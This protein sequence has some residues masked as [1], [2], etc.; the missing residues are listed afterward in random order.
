[1]AETVYY[2]WRDRILEAGRGAMAGKE[3]D[4]ERT[5]ERELQRKVAELERALDRKPSSRRSAKSNG[6][7]AV[8]VRV[9]RSR[10]LGAAGFALAAGVAL[11]HARRA[12]SGMSRHVLV[13]QRMK[14]N[15]DERGF[16]EWSPRWPSTSTRWPFPR[17]AFGRR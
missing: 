4:E 8:S 16:G 12:T 7:L 5:S 15:L 2:G 17:R 9:S 14:T 13:G 10:V 11:G 1:M 6:D 3:A